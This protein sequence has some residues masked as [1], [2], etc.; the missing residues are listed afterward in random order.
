MTIKIPPETIKTVPIKIGT[1][2]LSISRRSNQLIKSAK[3]GAVAERGET[4][5]KSP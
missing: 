4:M 3:I 5:V 1:V 2:T